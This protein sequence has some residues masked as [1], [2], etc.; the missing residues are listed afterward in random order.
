M[1]FCANRNWQLGGGGV[2]ISLT[3][4]G[5]PEKTFVI[6]LI[7]SKLRSEDHIV[8]AVASSGFGA[9]LSEGAMIPR[10]R[11]KISIDIHNNSMYNISVQSHL[12][13]L[14]RQ[15][16][17]VFWDEVMMQHHNIFQTIDRTFQDI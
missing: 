9:I 10:S 1:T 13:E 6:N 14:I 5:G 4:F 7:L 12:A 8:F 11:F 15:R 3:V 2:Y 17:L 16:N